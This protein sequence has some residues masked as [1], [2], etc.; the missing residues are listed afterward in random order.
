MS[1]Q[2]LRDLERRYRET[3]SLDDEA[4]YIQERVRAGILPR[5]RAE[6]AAYCD[7]EAAKR[8]M[9][10]TSPSDRKRLAATLATVGAQVSQKIVACMAITAARAAAECAHLSAPEPLAALVA[11]EK[12]LISPTPER[13]Q[14]ADALSRIAI[15]SGALRQLATSENKV[16]NRAD[17]AAS[18]TGIV[19]GARSLR[20]ITA[21]SQSC[22]T[23][24]L[25]SAPDAVLERLRAVVVP[26]L[27]LT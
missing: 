12:W 4:A 2:K 15:H 22:L 18:G 11:A 5:V 21:A 8:A 9:A 19:A 6:L 20:E 7:H 3:G 23:S 1:D 10:I 26:M 14:E 16:L 25:M 27:E 13:A 17:G 24:A